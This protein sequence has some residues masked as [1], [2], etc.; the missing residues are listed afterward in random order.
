METD[1]TSLVIF[2]LPV[3]INDSAVSVRWVQRIVKTFRLNEKAENNPEK[4]TMVPGNGVCVILSDLEGVGKGADEMLQ[5]ALV[6]MGLH[7]NN[8]SCFR[9]RNTPVWPRVTQR[10][11]EP[12]S[13]Q[14]N[15]SATG[16]TRF[17]AG[18]K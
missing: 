8:E 4:E 11:S 12:V 9:F 1:F 16:N 10:L 3:T 14:R 15:R 17:P 6:Q 13:V 18:L 7:G 5:Q 2:K